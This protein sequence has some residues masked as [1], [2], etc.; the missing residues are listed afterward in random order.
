MQP[1][2]QTGKLQSLLLLCLFSL[3][4]NPTFI[5]YKYIKLFNL[6]YATEQVFLGVNFAMQ[7]WHFSSFH[8]LYWPQAFRE[9][10]VN[11]L[12]TAV[13]DSDSCEENGTVYS[14][15]EIWQPELCRTCVCDSGLV[16]CEDEV[17]EELR[18]CRM[19]VFPKGECCPR[20]SAST[21]TQTT[22]S[23]AGKL[24]RMTL[25]LYHRDL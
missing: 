6:F 18:D 7:V 17:C 5:P 13:L 25:F 23:G 21:L 11:M 3:N 22:N 14:N 9:R 8:P 16:V 20:C 2:G 12:A 19:V 15:N 10:H 4:I 1:S 24:N